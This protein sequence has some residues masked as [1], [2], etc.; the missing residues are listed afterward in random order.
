M[1]ERQAAPTP[2]S[3]RPQRHWPSDDASGGPWQG[4]LRLIRQ[5][6]PPNSTRLLGLLTLVVSGGILLALAGITFTGFALAVVFLGPILLLTSPVWVPAAALVFGATAVVLSACGF[7][8]AAVAGA[9]WVYRYAI[10][11]HP[12]GSDRVDY[13]RSRIADTA[14][15]VK[16]YAREYGGYLKGRVKDAAPGA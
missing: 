7:G 16:D 2:A 3:A 13:A 5:H 10:G 1:A 12:V 15:H 6:A 14:S 9:T 11:R 4:L 8:V